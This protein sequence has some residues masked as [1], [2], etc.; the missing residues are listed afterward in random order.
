MGTCPV[1]RRWLPIRLDEESFR[2]GVLGFQGDG[3]LLDHDVPLE[4]IIH[5]EYVNQDGETRE[6]AGPLRPDGRIEL[7]PGDT[8]V[9]AV[10]RI[11]L[12]SGQWTHWLTD[13]RSYHDY[14]PPE[15][16]P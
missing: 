13:L 12:D 16:T 11:W 2:C 3:Y 14:R 6:Y 4:T 9:R 15:A 10:H 5:V 8:G 7:A 1:C